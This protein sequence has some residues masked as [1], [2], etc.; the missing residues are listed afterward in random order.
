MSSVK[1]KAPLGGSVTLSSV[2]TATDYTLT[3]PAANATVITTASSA[4]IT[5]SM[6]GTNVTGNGP[7]F[8]ASKNSGQAITTS[9]WTKIQFNV[10]DW[11]TN[12]N[13]DNATNY[14]FTPTVAGYYQVDLAIEFNNV[15]GSY[16]AAIYKNGSVYIFS[17][18]YAGSTIGSHPNVHGLIYMNGSTDYIEGYAYTTTAS[19]ALYNG[20]ATYFNA[21]MVRA[22]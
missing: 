14:R 12:S 16:I 13:Y 17:A 8:R 20:S 2:D 15:S 18:F 4:N 22:A 1:L 10:E 11:D 5:Q 6:L 21:S 19:Q 7:S 3:V 9:T